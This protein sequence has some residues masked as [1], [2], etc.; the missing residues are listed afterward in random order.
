MESSL[1]DGRLSLK[2][3]IQEINSSIGWCSS[4]TIMDPLLE[5]IMNFALH[6]MQSYS[7]GYVGYAWYGSVRYMGCGSV[8]YVGCGSVGYVG[9]GSVGYVGCGSVGYVG[10]GSVGYVGYGIEYCL[11]KGI[12]KG[13]PASNPNH[14]SLDTAIHMSDHPISSMY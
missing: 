4:C 12:L 8:G 14:Y 2:N 13:F 9:C 3:S 11:I 6:S 10:C 1:H 7:V 5:M